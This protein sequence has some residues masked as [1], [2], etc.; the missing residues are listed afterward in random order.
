MGNFNNWEI[1]SDFHW[2]G[3]PWGPYLDWPHPSIWFATGRDAL[4]A[5]WDYKKKGLAATVWVPDYFCPEVLAYWIKNKINIR[6]YFDNPLMPHPD[7]NTINCAPKDIVLAVNFFGLRD[8]KP[9]VHWKK[10]NDKVIL[11]EDHTHDPFSEWALNSEAD[12][13]FASIRKICPIPDGAFLWSPRRRKLPAPILIDDWS[14]SSY[15]LAA[16]V[17]KRDFLNV[18]SKNLELKE[19][20]RDFQ[21]KGE[22]L[23]GKLSYISLSPW[24][25]SLIAK[26]YSKEWRKAREGNVRYFWRLLKDK[27]PLIETHF[28]VWPN[29]GCPFNAILLLPTKETRDNLRSR[30]IERDIYPAIHWLPNKFSSHDSINLSN[31]ILTISV[32]Q[33]Y[34][35]Q[36]IERIVD[37]IFD[38]IR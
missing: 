36:D 14:A 12:Y 27:V 19:I 18:V 17:I 32:D 3:Y 22:E 37:I 30:L 33:R 34:S 20:Y 15:K 38:L 13:A 16:M 28:A 2:I 1:G 24:S 8:W 29:N 6:P 21:A 9:W 25:R 4:L 7:W 31:R 26:G 10:K 11:V 5:L 23:Y 35:S